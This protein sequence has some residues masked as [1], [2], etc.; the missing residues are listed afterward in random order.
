MSNWLFLSQILPRWGFPCS[1]LTL[2]SAHFN[3]IL[4]NNLHALLRSMW[5]SF[6]FPKMKTVK[7]SVLF[8]WHLSPELTWDQ[9]QL[10]FSPLRQ[11]LMEGK[12]CEQSIEAI[13]FLILF[14]FKFIGCNFRSEAEVICSC[15][16]VGL[17]SFEFCN[18]LLQVRPI[19]TF[20]S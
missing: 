8:G 4:S 13:N 20:L 15:W 9:N 6:S 17:V 19:R 2:L 7:S 10:L 12:F 14:Y 16:Y 1:L 11:E 3:G 5:S 18:L